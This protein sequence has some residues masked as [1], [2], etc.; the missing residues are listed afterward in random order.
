MKKSV[1]YS[2]KLIQKYERLLELIFS[3]GAYCL[4]KKNYE[5]IKIFLE[6]KQPADAD[7]TW[8]GHDIIPTSLKE[9]MNIMYKGIPFNDNFSFKEGHHGATIYKKRYFILLLLILLKSLPTDEEG[10]CSEIRNYRLPELSIVTLG[11]LETR[12]DQ[13]TKVAQDLQRDEEIF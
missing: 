4:F 11:S 8:V 9:V 10:N 13:L 7:A 12:V 6:Y 5:F 2:E 1:E 3:A